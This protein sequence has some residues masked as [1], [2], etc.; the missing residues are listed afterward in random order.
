MPGLIARIE[1]EGVTT[2]VAPP[3]TYAAIAAALHAE[4]RTLDAPLLQQCIAGNAP[5]DPALDALWRDV[6]AVSLA[7]APTLGEDD[8][9][10]HPSKGARA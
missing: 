5:I 2:L 8:R 1:R 9:S 6:S 7:P 3:A 4:A 10:A